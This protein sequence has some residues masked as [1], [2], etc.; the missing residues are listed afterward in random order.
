MSL[1]DL[2]DTDEAREGKRRGKNLFWPK[3]KKRKKK[4]LNHHF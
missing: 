1:R 3:K 2:W 4:T